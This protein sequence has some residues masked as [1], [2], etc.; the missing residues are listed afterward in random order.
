M[1]SYVPYHKLN[2]EIYGI[3]SGTGKAIIEGETVELAAGGRLGIA[4]AAKRRFFAGSDSALGH[5]C[6]QVKE[7]SPE[8]FTA[9]GVV[10]E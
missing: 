5:I 4:P 2:E 6:I 9:D 10:V 7:N 8:A 1:K 3:I